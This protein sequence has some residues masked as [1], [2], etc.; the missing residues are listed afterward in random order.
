MQED[1]EEE[2]EGTE[3]GRK[4]ELEESTHSVSYSQSVRLVSLSL[5]DSR[6]RR[7]RKLLS[8]RDKHYDVFCSRR[9]ELFFLSRS[10]SSSFPL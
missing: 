3:D 4:K 7:E 10:S 2:A 5:E 6:V 1:D 9:S 8:M